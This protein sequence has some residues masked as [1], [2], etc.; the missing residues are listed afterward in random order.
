[1]R[2]TLLTATGWTAFIF[3]VYVFLGFRPAPPQTIGE[4]EVCYKCHHVI[5]SAKLAAE[6][7]DRNLPTK[8]RTA[9]C[10]AAYAAAHPSN[11]ARYYVTDFVSGGLIEAEHAFF[12]PVVINDKTNERD[13]RA[14]YSRGMADIAAQVLGVQVV[15]WDAL[16]KNARE[17]A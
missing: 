1:M 12:V 3:A 16:V 11:D 9:G 13:Y 10:M 4:G 6:I 5:T 14:Y 8:Y 15:R 2:R 7:M 17:R